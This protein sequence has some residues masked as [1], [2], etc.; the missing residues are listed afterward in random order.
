MRPDAGWERAYVD[1]I[2]NPGVT[3]WLR[4]LTQGF[5]VFRESP[6]RSI[7]KSVSYRITGSLTTMAIVAAMTGR[8]QLAVGVGT[9]DLV[10]K[11]ILYYLHERAWD[12]VSLGRKRIEPCVLWFTGLSGSGKSTIADK[13][14]AEILA[15]GL[16]AERLDGDSI[17]NLFP[18]TGF[19]KAD[20]DAHIKRV[21]FLASKLESN[22]VF[23]IASFVS[24][25]AEARTFVRGLCKQFVEIHVSTPIEICEKRD[26]KGLYAKARRG[27]IKNFTGI[28]DPYEPPANAELT[29]DTS[30]TEVDACVK[31]VMALVEI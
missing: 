3:S 23:V 26:V 21:G 16:R 5:T 27:E 24:P 11:L 1:T 2:T 30:E 29:L 28:D 9:L 7:G 22:D 13:V 6:L 20:R 12:N 19:T 17:R 25:Y 18:A 8:F 14:H 10:S 15:R 4:F 31:R